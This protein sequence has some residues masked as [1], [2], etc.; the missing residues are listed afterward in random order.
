MTTEH[1]SET[2][3]EHAPHGSLTI[4]S[5][6]CQAARDLASYDFPS[7]E[8]AQC[9]YPFYES[10]RREAPIYKLP[11]RNDFLVSRRADILAV[12]SDYRTFSS[13]SWRSPGEQRR[14]TAAGQLIEDLPDMPEGPISHPHSM[15]STDPPEHRFK[16]RP[17]L[18]VVSKAYLEQQRP[19][20]ERLA[21]ELIDT[22]IERGDAELRSEFADRMAVLTIC[23]MVGFPAEDRDVF[24]GWR[25]IGTG[26]GRRYLTDE[27]LAEQDRDRPAEA[28]YCH[29]LIIERY[30]NPRDDFLSRFIA[31]QVERDGALN[32]PY[33]ITET[34]LLLVAG[35]ETTSRLITN[36]LLLL[37]RNPDQLAKLQADLSLVQNTIEEALRF[38]A[39]TQWTNRTSVADTEVNGV[40]IPA[41]STMVLLY[42]SANREPEVWGADANQFRIDRPEVQKKHVA[43][44]G[45][46]HLCFGAPLARVESAISLEA[47]ITRLK[48]IRLAPGKNDFANIENFQKRVPEVL[49]GEFDPGERVLGG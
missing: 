36:A 42:G 34:N 6:L 20:I 25:R 44:G 2:A 3:S 46:P 12:L 33:L 35:N 1:A 15:S 4:G 41:G 24:L 13:E 9:P 38:E 19:H 26:A 40:P 47:L 32:L 21:H 16:R 22:F 37:L 39:P 11:G 7:D 14:I 31:N 43:F 30:E 17:A 29:D 18:E 28:Q 23:H 27:Q 48:N 49:Y 8:L 10:A 45:G 5:E